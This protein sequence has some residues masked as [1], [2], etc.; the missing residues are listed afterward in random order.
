MGV[1][2]EARMRLSSYIDEFVVTTVYVYACMVVG[3]KK[4]GVEPLYD[5]V[6][7]KIAFR[8]RNEE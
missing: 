4:I 3:R 8:V 5:R 7:C 6:V 2:L 1:F